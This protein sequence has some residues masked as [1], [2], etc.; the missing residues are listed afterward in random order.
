[1]RSVR[2]LLQRILLRRSYV[3]SQRTEMLERAVGTVEDEGQHVGAVLLAA[4]HE[5]SQVRLVRDHERHVSLAARHLE[6]HVARALSRR[7]GQVER[8]VGERELERD[9]LV[10]DRARAEY[11]QCLGRHRHRQVHGGDALVVGHRG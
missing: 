5:P 10:V 2:P 6:L 4:A 3:T 7:L 11:G 9:L 8:D 1:M